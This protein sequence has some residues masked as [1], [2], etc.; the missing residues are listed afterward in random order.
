MMGQLA[1]TLNL[2]LHKY[3]AQQCNHVKEKLQ[4]VLRRSEIF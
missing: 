4:E 1:R 2:I 3:G